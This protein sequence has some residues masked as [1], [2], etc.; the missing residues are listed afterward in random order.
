MSTQED[1][2]NGRMP[3]SESARRLPTHA[4][5]DLVHRPVLAAPDCMTF[6]CAQD[7]CSHGADVWPA[8][9]EALIAAGHAG[10]GQ[11][12]GP[13]LDDDGD[14]LYRTA[15]GPRGCVFLV[16]EGRGCGLHV[17]GLKPEVCRVVPRDPD[18][19]DE[20]HGDGQLPCRSSWRFG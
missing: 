4:V 2:S 17:T 3:P 19:A 1:P 6:P 18:E 15:V 8:E 16:A 10:A 11:F 5:A 12:T 20:L 14:L 7:C 9:R 13:E